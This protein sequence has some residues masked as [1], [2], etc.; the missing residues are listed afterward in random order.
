MPE[1]YVVLLKYLLVM[2]SFKGCLSSEEAANAVKKGL[3]GGT[4]IPFSDGGEGFVQCIHRLCGG[5][6][7]YF[8]TT[9]SYG[10]EIRSHYLRMGD[11]AVIE[12]ALA[13]GLEAVGKD[14][15][16]I[17]YARSFGT[18]TAIKKALEDGCTQ[19]IIGFG[20]SAVNDGGAGALLALGARLEGDEGPVALAGE[21]CTSVDL[22]SVT[23][24]LKKARITFACD[25]ENVY[26]GD[27]GASMVFSLQKGADT[28]TAVR[29][30]KSHRA[31]ARLLKA[32]SGKDISNAIGAGAAGGLAGGL[33][34]VC[35]PEIQS[36]FQVLSRLCSLDEKVKAADIVITG[37]GKTDSQTLMGKLPKRITDLAKKYS[38]TVLCV[39]G[40]V[41]DGGRRL[42]ADAFFSLTGDG[43]TQEMS[44]NDPER[45]L[46]LAGQKIKSTYGECEK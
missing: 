33:M 41:T 9:D 12:T 40:T 38:K 7:I 27:K 6:K 14:H 29:M 34:A 23:P 18:G 19:L 15:P 26:C 32:A 31:F 16:D 45:Y 10:R 25:V 39:S 11:T 21:W 37:E 22:K 44:L 13:D 5:K 2:D 17:I 30:E 20:G 8:P 3:G 28:K 1:R 4:V 46:F 24:L 42:G 43:V 36:G 35:E